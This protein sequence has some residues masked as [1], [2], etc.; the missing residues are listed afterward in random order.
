MDHEDSAPRE[1]SAPVGPQEEEW[2][3]EV[4]SEA[5]P[6]PVVPEAPAEPAPATGAGTDASVEASQAE[7]AAVSLRRRQARPGSDRRPLAPR[8][9]P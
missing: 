5:L 3:S 7:T 2:A 9:A 4:G 1:G 8:E 6:Q